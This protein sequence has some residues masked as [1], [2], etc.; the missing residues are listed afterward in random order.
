MRLAIHHPG[1]STAQATL[2]LKGR[3][4]LQPCARGVE[5]K[6]K[7]AGRDIA[8]L[9]ATRKSRVSSP[10]SSPVE[11][12]ALITTLPSEINNSKTKRPNSKI[13]PGKMTVDQAT[14]KKGLQA[15]RKN[16]RHAK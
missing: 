5:G 6:L 14:V 10:A 13:S 7:P 2:A 9:S 8:G 4:E 11:H 15:F 16:E 1:T 12:D 3:K